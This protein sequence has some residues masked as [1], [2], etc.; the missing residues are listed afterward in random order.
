MIDRFLSLVKPQSAS[1]HPQNLARILWQGK[2]GPAFWTISS[3]ISITVNVILIVI[4]ITVGRQLIGLKN[5]VSDQLIGGLHQ[6][7]VKMDQ[8]HI[9]TTITVD[10][11][12][13]VNDSIPVV[14]DL[15]LQQNT[16][17]VLTEDTPVKKAQVYLNGVSVPTDIV[18]RKGTAL[19]VALNLTVP[20][21]QTIPVVLDV[22]VHLEVPVDIALDQ[23]ELHEPFTGLQAV[24][25]PYQELLSGLPSSWEETPLCGSQPGL[26][27]DWLNGEVR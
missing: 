13:Q 25:S 11:T 15:P 27:C 1:A 16:Q 17:V 10:D 21:N 19:N 7:F 24:V 6:N 26:L 4:L 3:L 18:L 23:T 5:L 12:I 8:A 2:L 14:F 9:R 22:P 20:V